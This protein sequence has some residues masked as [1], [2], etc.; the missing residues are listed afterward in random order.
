M[1][2]LAANANVEA[3]SHP[4]FFLWAAL[5]CLLLAFGG[6]SHTYFA[7]MAA[8]TLREVSF[9]VHIHGFLF[10]G[11]TILFVLQVA[12]IAKD[13]KSTHRSLGLIGI[14][15]A[16]AMVIFG[17]LV[18]LLSNAK[19]FDSGAIDFA[20]VGLLSGTGAMI[21]FGA[22]FALAIRNVR[23]P[24]CHKRFMLLATTAILGA[25][26]ARLW[27]PFFEFQQVP[28]WLWRTTQDL[29]ILALFIYDWRT[30][31]KPHVV[32]GVFG[33]VII[34][35]HAL[36]VPVANTDAFQTVAQAWF[37]VLN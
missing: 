36:N 26:T 16:T 27:G 19:R 3:H 7:P 18:S 35:L 23:R 5:T 34:V 31:G 2:E 25:A 24:D 17:V 14:S 12:L 1:A 10:F 30:L 29:P 37:A 33:T 32:T 6:F 15:L 22:M 8:G 13:R 4:R 20:Y 28:M 9:A 21:A 11:W